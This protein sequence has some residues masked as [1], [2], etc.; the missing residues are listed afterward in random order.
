M[1]DMVRTLVRDA[2]ADTPVKTTLGAILL[3]AAIVAS[4]YWLPVLEMFP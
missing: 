1:T 4:S 3:C 2:W